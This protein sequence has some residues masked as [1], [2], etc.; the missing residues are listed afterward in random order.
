M[1]D[2]LANGVTFLYF[3]AAAILLL[4]GFNCYII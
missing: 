4:Y 1:L 3:S 2:I